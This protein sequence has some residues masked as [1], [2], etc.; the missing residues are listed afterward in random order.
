MRKALAEIFG[1][2]PSQ[3]RVIVGPLGGGYGGKGHI[4]LEPLVAALA[5]KIGGRPVKLVATRAEEFV[6]VT[7][8]AATI[9]IKS[10]V[11]RDGTLTA[12]EVTSWWSVGAYADASWMLTR[13]GML[14]SIGPY[15]IGAVRADSYGIYTNRPPAAAFRGAMA[16]Q[17]AWA[18][19]SHMDSI[20]H[21]LGLDPLELRR[22]NLLHEGDIWAN[23][24]HMHEV[25]YQE[26]LDECLRQLDWD[27]A[28]CAR[29]RADPARPRGGGDDEE[30][31]ERLALRG[32]GS[33]CATMV[34]RSSIPARSRWARA[35]TPPW[36][37]SRPTPSGCPMQALQV[38]G[39]DTE[40]S[41]FEAGTSGSRTTYRWATRCGALRRPWPPS[42]ARWAA[43]ASR[44]SQRT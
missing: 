38:I 11:M 39:P 4:R 3:V 10:G 17:G 27:A 44:S 15:R 42:C 37:R 21:R 29:L 14:R 43:A 7:K 19:E 30:R 40:Q 8:H 16:S 28:A 13:G 9:T 6:I 5:W 1:L 20:A 22:K 32:A 25:H 31:P 36:R 23:G 12:R 34:G 35:P 33:C 2:R 41:P 24:K 18:Y 26:L